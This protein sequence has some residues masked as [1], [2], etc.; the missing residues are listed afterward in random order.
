MNDKLTPKLIRYNAAWQADPTDNWYYYEDV[1]EVI[2][3]LQAEV[4]AGN[5]AIGLQA[6]T[7]TKLQ[8]DFDSLLKERN[9]LAESLVQANLDLTRLEK[10]R[11]QWED[12]YDECVKVIEK[13]DES[14]MPK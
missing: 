5:T 8:A 4:T 7:I 1:D 9:H 10:R 6:Q 12:D 14:K 2:E 11:Q 3:Q 13:Q